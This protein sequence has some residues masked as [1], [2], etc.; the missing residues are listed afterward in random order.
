MDVRTTTAT[1]AD[2]LPILIAAF[3]D[4]LT[5]AG[6]A[7]HRLAARRALVQTFAQWTHDR[8]VAVADLREDHVRAFV[9]TCRAHSPYR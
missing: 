2:P 9:L 3:L 6:Y 7:P 5:A 1:D 8:Q 4:D